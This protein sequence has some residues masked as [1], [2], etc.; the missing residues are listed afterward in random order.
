MRPVQSGYS[1]DPKR[2][3]RLHGSR[4]HIW[5]LRTKHKKKRFLLLSLWN[6]IRYIDKLIQTW[7]SIQ[8]IRVESIETC[9]S[10]E[11]RLSPLCLCSANRSVTL[12]SWSLRHPSQSAA[13]AGKHASDQGRV[14]SQPKFFDKVSIHLWVAVDHHDLDTDNQWPLILWTNAQNK[15]TENNKV[16]GRSI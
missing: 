6:S 3:K 7:T 11:H 2:C 9:S 1:R 4:T 14:I 10:H 5:P 16:A 13:Q 12:F 8:V 15:P